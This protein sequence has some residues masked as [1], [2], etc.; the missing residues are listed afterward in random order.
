MNAS[1]MFDSGPIVATPGALDALLR[2]NKVPANY[3]QRHLQGDWGTICEDD[4]AANQEA[5]NDGSRLMSEYLLP[6]EEK[7]WIISD[8]VIDELGNRQATTLLLPDEY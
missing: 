2:N 6:D 3:L 5:L 7:L 1:K 8:A 4:K